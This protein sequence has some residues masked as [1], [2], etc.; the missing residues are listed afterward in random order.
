MQPVGKTRQQRGGQVPVQSAVL[1]H[2]PNL[3]ARLQQGAGERAK[4]RADF[5]HRVARR[6]LAVF[7]RLADYIAVDQKVLSEKPLRVVPQLIEQRAGFVGSQGHGRRRC[8]AS[9]SRCETPR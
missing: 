5:H 9:L 3:R 2:R 8:P 7:E 6:D 4:S 1:L